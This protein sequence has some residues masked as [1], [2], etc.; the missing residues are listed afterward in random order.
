MASLY[1]LQYSIY[2]W[3]KSTILVYKMCTLNTPK[4][5]LELKSVIMRLKSMDLKIFR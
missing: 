3:C 4:L 2:I 5:Y 1:S